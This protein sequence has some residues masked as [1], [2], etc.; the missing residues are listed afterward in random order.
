MVNHEG[1]FAAA[2][3]G[4]M[5]RNRL[6]FTTEVP[7]QLVVLDPNLCMVDH[8]YVRILQRYKELLRNSGSM[9][10]EVT[11]RHIVFIVLANFGY[12]WMF[13]RLFQ[14]L[15]VMDSAGSS[16][17]SP[18][19]SKKRLTVSALFKSPQKKM[20][21]EQ[22]QVGAKRKRNLMTEEEPTRLKKRRRSDEGAH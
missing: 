20:S 9:D 21:E 6:A 18:L 7:E 8:Q 16:V 11:I 2:V 19:D 1:G 10:A 17:N 14:D 22:S 5:A 15:K 12:N 4:L 3:V 13:G